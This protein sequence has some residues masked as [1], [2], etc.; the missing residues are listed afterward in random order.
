MG[1]VPPRSGVFP[2]KYHRRS[3]RLF[4]DGRLCY[5]RQKLLLPWRVLCRKFFDLNKLVCGHVSEYLPGFAGGPPD[6][7]LLDLSL[8]AQSD[9]LL[10]WVR[11]KGPAASHRAIDGTKS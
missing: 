11:P 4:A 10:Q 7:N 5:W 8:P 2:H 3:S 9:V 6:L 1:F